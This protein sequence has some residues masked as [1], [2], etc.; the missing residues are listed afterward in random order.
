MKMNRAKKGAVV[1]KGTVP[2]RDREKR[3]SALLYR[4]TV[5]SEYDREKCHL[6]PCDQRFL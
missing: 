3:G 5:G 2:E 1:L 6:L 4:W